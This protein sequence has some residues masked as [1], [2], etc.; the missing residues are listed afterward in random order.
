VSDQR[1]GTASLPERQGE[2]DLWAAPRP[3]WRPVE[4]LT[5]PLQ[6]VRNTK[7]VEVDLGNVFRKLGLRSRGRIAQAL[8]AR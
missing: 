7:T 4:S 1:S 3:N 6:A 2:H 5:G 8:G